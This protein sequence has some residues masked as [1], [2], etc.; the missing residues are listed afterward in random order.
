MIYSKTSIPIN[1]H[2]DESRFCGASLFY[3]FQI[4]Q[5][6]PRHTGMRFNLNT[7]TTTIKSLIAISA[8][9]KLLKI[10]LSF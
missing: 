9:S 6:M 1:V 8:F 10:V 3:S 4:T 2:E 5:A 7:Q